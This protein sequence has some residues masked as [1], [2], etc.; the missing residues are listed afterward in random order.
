MTVT[1]K[2][3]SVTRLKSRRSDFSNMSV[4]AVADIIAD[5]DRDET[6]LAEEAVLSLA[7]W[8]D[9]QIDRRFH[10]LEYGEELEETNQRLMR[11][12]HDNEKRASQIK[13]ILADAASWEKRYPALIELAKKLG[14][15]LPP[16]DDI[17]F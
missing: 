14:V 1:I 6:T 9:A 12:I 7:Q 13:A 10:M 17:P 5:D 4:T 16:L 8:C 15:E 11:D 2:Q 3:V